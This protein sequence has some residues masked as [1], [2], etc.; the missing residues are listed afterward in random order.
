MSDSGDT[1]ARR[2]PRQERSRA[3]VEAIL[4]AARRILT[5]DG[6]AALTTSRI[7]DLAGVSVG[8][9]YRYFPN[10]QA[11]V[12]AVLET[13][14]DEESRASADEDAIVERLSRVP[15]EEAIR[16]IVLYNVDYHRQQLAL[17]ESFYQAHHREFS[18]GA[19]IGRHAG[20]RRIRRV[21]EAHAAALQI[22]DLDAAVF[23]LARGPS[24]LTR[25]TLEESP[26]LLGEPDYIEDLVRLFLLF[27]GLRAPP[28]A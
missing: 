23:L 13:L 15:P 7:A 25:V 9:L 4:E 17:G 27:F 12:A 1:R 24:S 2:V 26:E 19:R 11:I 16:A 21:L 22:R 5:H 20:L 18:V 14:Q 3:I 10:K 8:S 6:L 28:S